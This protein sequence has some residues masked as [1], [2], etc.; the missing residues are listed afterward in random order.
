MEILTSDA[1]SVRTT[2][3]DWQAVMRAA[4]R[5]LPSL[6]EQLQRPA[7]IEH[8]LARPSTGAAESP[9]SPPESPAT[10]PFPLF[11]PP[12]FV[13]KIERGNWQ[14]PL[15]L[16][17]L[18]T[19]QERVQDPS[20]VP[21]PVGDLPATRTAGLLHKYRGRALLLLNGVCAIHCRYCFRQHF[22][23]ADASLSGTRW[24]AAIAA[25]R[26]DATLRE[27]IL[28]GGDPLTWTDDRLRRSVDELAQVSHLT[29]LRIHSR[30]PVV[31][32]ERVTESLLEL[33]T[34]TR[35][36]PILVIHANHPRELD[37]EVQNR[38]HRLAAAGV[39]LFNQAV[40]LR[41]V[42]DSAE[43]LVG[44]SERLIECRTTPYY[45]HQLDRVAGAAHFE[46]SPHRGLE[47]MEALREQ[48]PGYA[49]PRY[50]REVA[51]GAA[52]EPVEVARRDA[53]TL[54][55]ET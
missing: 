12:R 52:K 45:L 2:P 4:W 13:A 3:A 47:L 41:G 20:F 36:Q 19:A 33:L 25:I 30:L 53:P 15:L 5:D 38:L 22:P 54:H 42:N 10:S 43:V 17:I 32:P 31:I 24:D 14:D 37:D 34:A 27:I 39:V 35:L 55:R 40:L 8:G 50:V 21:D 48:L 9:K 51:G 23:Y 44:L 18:P 28:S 49:V 16:Q 29:R 7:T 6:C 26:E 11:A 46:V 1:Y